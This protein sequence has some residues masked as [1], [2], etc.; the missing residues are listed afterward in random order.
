MSLQFVQFLSSGKNRSLVYKDV[1]LDCGYRIDLLVAGKV[2]LEIK[3][4]DSLAPIHEAILLTY[5]PLSGCTLGLLI[6]FHVVLLKDGVKRLVL[7]YPS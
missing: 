5:L 1:R 7:H 3:A 4:V 6:N 2:V